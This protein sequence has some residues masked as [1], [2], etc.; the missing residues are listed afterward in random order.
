MA[1]PEA[2]LSSKIVKWLNEQP[3]V[4][5]RKKHQSQYGHKGDPDI[6]GCVFGRFF[7]IEV[8]IGKNTPTKIQSKC[9]EDIAAAGGITGVAYNLDDVKEILGPYM[10]TAVEI[11]NYSDYTFDAVSVSIE[12]TVK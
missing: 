10:T 2:Q 3:G 8:K 6:H 4:W 1:Q 12:R 9:L 11:P 5:A 7:G